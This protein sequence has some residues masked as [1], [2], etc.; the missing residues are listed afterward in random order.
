MAGGKG[1][2]RHSAPFLPPATTQTPENSF[3]RGVTTV[4]HVGSRACHLYRR[5]EMNATSLA[6]A[7]GEDMAELASTMLVGRE[8]MY[9]AVFKGM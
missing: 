3:L 9:V 6:F 5:G 8:S 1:E 7:N 2:F 4:L